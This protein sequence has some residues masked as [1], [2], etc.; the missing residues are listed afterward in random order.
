MVAFAAMTTL[1]GGPVRLIDSPIRYTQAR[2]AFGPP[3][4]FSAL[5][6]VVLNAVVVGMTTLVSQSR[7]SLMAPGL[8]EPLTTLVMPVPVVILLSIVM[9]L[10]GLAV[11]AGAVIMFDMA[12]VQSR[13]PRRFFE[14]CA[15]A[16]WPQVLV[17][18]PVLAATWLY[19]D[20]PVIVYRGA[21]ADA[22]AVAMDYGAE[23]GRMPFSILV[24]TVWQFAAVW[25]LALHACTLRVVSG[26]TVGATWAAGI[27]LAVLFIGVPWLAGQFMERLFF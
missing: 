10:L 6:P 7:M 11:H 19:F 5:S 14:L 18:I 1:K 2:A 8:S 21:G 9:G 17:S 27:G 4:L 23:V 15:L 25:L 12:T 13:Q 22:V 16:Y 20:P 24:D 26:L 3:R